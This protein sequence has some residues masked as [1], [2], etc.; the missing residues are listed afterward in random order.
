M[1]SYFKKIRSYL[2]KR[3]E[4][5]NLES[6]Y[7]KY[8]DFTMIHRYEYIDNLSIAKLTKALNGDVVECGVWR[9]GMSA[10]MAEVIGN[11]HKYYLFDSFEGL[12]EVKEIDGESAKKWQQDKTSPG[13]Y[14][15]CK[16]EIDFANKAMTMT[17]VNFECV[18]GWFEHTIPGF[19]RISSI[20]LL[21]LD[22]DWYDSTIVCLRNFYPKVVENGIILIDD[23]YAWTGC[24][25]AVHDY[26]SEIKSKSRIYSSP[27]GVAY[28]VK[29]I[30]D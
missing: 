8:A 23:Y 9:G 5:K 2:N 4:F 13:Y 18:K 12:P 7:N 27:A 26:L 15:N 11:N 1:L 24:S 19:D 3:K 22:G 16:A 14:D 10:G 20:S 6:I 28:I 17:G 30:Q 29:R 25:R 21:R